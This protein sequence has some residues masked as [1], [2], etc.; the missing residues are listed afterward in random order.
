[1]AISRVVFAA[2]AQLRHELGQSG[3]LGWEQLPEQTRLDIEARVRLINSHKVNNPAQMHDRWRDAMVK[4][5]W[6][7]GLIKDAANKKHPAICA[8]DELPIMEQAK[9]N[10]FWAVT[11]TLIFNYSYHVATGGD[12]N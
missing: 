2:V 7:A 3:G 1:V 4:D 10:L 9:Y 12:N 8:F 11:Q 6:T 5:G